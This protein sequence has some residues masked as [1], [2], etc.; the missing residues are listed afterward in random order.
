M[1]CTGSES[2]GR[3]DLSADRSEYRF[4]NSLMASLSSVISSTVR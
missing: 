2:F 1:T 4:S 3:R